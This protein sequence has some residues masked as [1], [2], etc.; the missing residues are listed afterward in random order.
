[1]I[2]K[3]ALTMIPAAVVLGAAAFS[4][5]QR[6]IAAPRQGISIGFKAEDAVTAE[7]KELR[8]LMGR[9]NNDADQLNTLVVSQLHWQ[10]HASQ[11]NQVKDRVNRIGDR[12]ETLRGMRSVAA[13]WQQEAVDDIM[14]VALEVAERTSAAI[15]HLN[16]N[17]QYL[18][19]PQ[20]LDY[21][22]TIA[23]RADQM[24]GLLDNHLKIIEARDKIQTLQEKLAERAS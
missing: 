4:S 8:T 9:L 19:A 11:L 7:L 14:P 10:T 21:L 24:Q 23:D 22:R 16:Q 1:M 20:Y 17:H 2:F 13:S 18:W 12:L 15:T 5:P 3:F 6:A